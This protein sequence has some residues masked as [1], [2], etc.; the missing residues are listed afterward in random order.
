[1]EVENMDTGIMFLRFNTPYT[2]EDSARLIKQTGFSSVMLWWYD[3]FLQAG[4]TSKLPS[5]GKK[6][7][8][9]DILRK[10]NINVC[11]IHAYSIISSNELWIEGILGER[12][13][14]EMLKSLKECSSIN[15]PIMVMH[16]T[17]GKF[18]PKPN[19]VG[20]SRIKFLAEQAQQYGITLA[21][22]NSCNSEHIDYLLDNI[23][24]TS[25]GLC[26]DSGHDFLYSKVPYEII[27]RH[28]KRIVAVHLHDNEGGNSV[29]HP[30]WHSDS[31]SIPG[32]GNIDWNIVKTALDYVGYK[33]VRLLEIESNT[34]LPSEAPECFLARA[35]KSLELLETGLK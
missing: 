31:H 4:F 7:E 14:E 3:N 18:P 15:V 11:Y 8:Q 10:Y 32:E 28:G 30:N 25:L 35:F 24:L 27:Y 19:E 29:K 2:M 22:E 1:M 33:G 20:L 6:E 5:K 21:I 34:A 16:V 26:Y 9:L 12:L 17:S 13:V 23:N